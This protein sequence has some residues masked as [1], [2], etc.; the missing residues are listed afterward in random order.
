[1]FFV[2]FFRNNSISASG[3]PHFC[4]L[5][6]ACF[7]TL[8]FRAPADVVIYLAFQVLF[9][10]IYYRPGWSAMCITDRSLIITLYSN[11]SDKEPQALLWAGSQAASVK[12]TVSG[13]PYR[14]HYGIYVYTVNEKCIAKPTEDEST[15]QHNKQNIT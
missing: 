14:L 4:H 11:L 6:Y 8:T 1:V 2:Y 10:Y 12:V 9:Q 13:I 15:A 3:K 5:N 7:K